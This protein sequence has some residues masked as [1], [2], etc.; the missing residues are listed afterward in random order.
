MSN[1]LIR[2]LPMFPIF[3]EGIIAF[4][5]GIY[6]LFSGKESFLM[7]GYRKK[8]NYEKNREKFVKM[9][10]V[11]DL[12]LGIILAVLLP[13]LYVKA[14]VGMILFISIPLLCVI[15][16]GQRVML[17]LFTDNLENRKN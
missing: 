16:I 6:Q 3:A 4:I 8:Y 14:S 1:V 11:L 12:S 13:V 10:G 2:I 7:Y 15:G 9:C 5:C 17:W